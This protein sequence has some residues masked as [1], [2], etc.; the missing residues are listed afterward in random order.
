MS[1]AQIVVDHDLMAMIEQQLRNGSAYISGPAG[2]KNSQ[3][4]F[5]PVSILTFSRASGRGQPADFK[6]PEIWR[7]SQGRGFQ[8]KITPEAVKLT[9]ALQAEHENFLC[10]PFVFPCGDFSRKSRSCFPTGYLSGTPLRDSRNMS[11]PYSDKSI[12][13]SGG[14]SLLKDEGALRL[15]L[16]GL[17]PGMQE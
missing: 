6:P 9:S 13:E 4:T 17:E 5:L 16:P 1:V 11:V 8:E 2:H 14:A 3:W 12:I 7:A 15:A 10:S